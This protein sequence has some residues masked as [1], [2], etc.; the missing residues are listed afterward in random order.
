[1]HEL[2]DE[3]NKK[4]ILMKRINRINE[5]FC[6]DYCFFEIKLLS[7]SQQLIDISNRNH[8]PIERFYLLFFSLLVIAPSLVYLSFL[9][10]L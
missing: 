1:M 5:N 2:N 4:K 3:S 8:Y 10:Q 6:N 7:Q 9:V